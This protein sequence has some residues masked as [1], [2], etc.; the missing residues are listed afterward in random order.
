M[1]VDMNRPVRTTWPVRVT[2]FTST[3]PR[4]VEMSPRRPAY[5]A[6]ISNPC[7][8]LPV[9]TTISTRS[10]LMGSILRSVGR[11]ARACGGC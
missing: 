7:T 8:P 10:P 5:G 4:E 11:T 2:S 1:R 3:T 9:S 6:E